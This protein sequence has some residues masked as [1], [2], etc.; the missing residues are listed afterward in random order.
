M[1]TDGRKTVELMS[2]DPETLTPIGERRIEYY[3]TRKLF[4]IQNVGCISIW[5][6]FTNI[7]LSLRAFLLK[8]ISA[9]IEIEKLADSLLQ[10]LKEN[11]DPSNNN[12]VG[13][14]VGGFSAD[15]YPKLFHVFFGVDRGPDI[16]TKNNPQGF[17]KYD[18]SNF[19]ALY[20]GANDK[21]YL[22]INFIL[23]IEQ[24][25]GIIN[26]ITKHSV[27]IAKKFIELI[28]KQVS[29]VEPT[30]GEE[31]LIAEI[32]KDNGI[33]INKTQLVSSDSDSS[34]YIIPSGICYT[35]PTGSVK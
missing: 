14:H 6:D 24:E 23:T 34:A 31:I 19:V 16:N 9:Q 30:V 20:N 12:D 35:P 26:W 17:K 11:I 29:Q 4:H 28:I 22:I 2:L 33:N 32:G 5:G 13:F 3:R 8:L 1:A 27:E 18:H 10:F 7:E 15:G 25:L 21:A